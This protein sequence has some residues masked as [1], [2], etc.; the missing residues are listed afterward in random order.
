LFP[1]PVS[2]YLQVKLNAGLGNFDISIFDANGRKV[3]FLYDEYSRRLDV[4]GLS[5]GIYLLN[6]KFNNST[7]TTRFLK[8]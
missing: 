4:S 8:F 6:L 1:N 2:D 7:Y 3:T 5:S